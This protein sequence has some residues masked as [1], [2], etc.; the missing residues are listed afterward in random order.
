MVWR[1]GVLPTFQIKNLLASTSGQSK[2]NEEEV[3]DIWGRKTGLRLVKVKEYW[4]LLK[5]L[6]CKRDKPEKK[7][8]KKQGECRGH[9]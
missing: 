9:N 7:Y 8:K 2:P 5:E 6:S 3:C 4:T 1:W